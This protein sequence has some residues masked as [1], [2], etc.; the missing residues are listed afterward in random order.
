MKCSFGGNKSFRR[1]QPLLSPVKVLISLMRSCQV[2]SL[3]WVVSVR[4]PPRFSSGETRDPII[5]TRGGCLRR[6]TPV[7][8]WAEAG[9]KKR[10]NEEVSKRHWYVEPKCLA[11]CFKSP[12]F[13]PPERSSEPLT[14]RFFAAFR[15]TTW[16]GKLPCS[17]AHS[18]R[19]LG[20]RFLTPDAQPYT[21]TPV[22]ASLRTRI[23]PHEARPTVHARS[24]GLRRQ[25]LS[26]SRS[27]PPRSVGLRSRSWEPSWA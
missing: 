27:V 10:R 12:L 18:A 15:M 5:R 19:Y 17:R 13:Y 6:G 7:P 25:D 16:A 4:R 22:P 26:E 24:F 9:E 14:V 23:C 21:L 11:M 1:L 20:F 8:I 3:T 2:L